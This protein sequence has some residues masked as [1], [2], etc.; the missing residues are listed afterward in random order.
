MSHL[1]STPLPPPPLS[2]LSPMTDADIIGARRTSGKSLPPNPW[3][4]RPFNVRR[5]RCAYQHL[6]RY[7]YHLLTGEDEQGARLFGK[8]PGYL[9]RAVLAGWITLEEPGYDR[10]TKNFRNKFP[11]LV[12]IDAE[13]NAT[14]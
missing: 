1:N 9:I 2:A 10:F 3:A 5:I 7:A 12:A 13:R 6:L 4:K 14:N 8:Q 11:H